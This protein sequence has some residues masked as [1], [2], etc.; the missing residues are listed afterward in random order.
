VRY[1]PHWVS[2]FGHFRLLRL[3][4][5]HRNFSQ[6]TTSFFGTTRPGIPRMLLFT[7]ATCDTEKSILS[8][9]VLTSY[10]F[11]LFV[12]MHLLSCVRC[13]FPHQR[14]PTNHSLV[15]A[16]PPIRSRSSGCSSTTSHKN[17]PVH[18]PGCLIAFLIY[19]L[20]AIL[21]AKPL[22]SSSNWFIA[23]LFLI[24]G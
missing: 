1:H 4:T 18:H 5:A 17:S 21:F 10:C 15:C 13:R 16:H 12:C 23:R 9:Y 22:C 2:P 11:V 6:C 20:E 19:L 24:H 7:F 3:H 8:R 14:L